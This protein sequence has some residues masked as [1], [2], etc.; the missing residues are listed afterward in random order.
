MG[1]GERMRCVNS[2]KANTVESNGH[3]KPRSEATESDTNAN[4]S[5][6]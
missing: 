2:L 1:V 3:T 6:A 4:R 5:F